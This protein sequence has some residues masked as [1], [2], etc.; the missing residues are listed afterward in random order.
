ME[1]SAPFLIT[2][3]SFNQCTSLDLKTLLCQIEFLLETGWY[4]LNMALDI[5]M[6]CEW[7]HRTPRMLLSEGTVCKGCF[8]DLSGTALFRRAQ[9]GSS[10]RCSMK[11]LFSTYSPSYYDGAR[12]QSSVKGWRMSWFDSPRPRPTASSISSL[13]FRIEGQRP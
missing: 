1:L 7:F 11:R 5:Q 13:G 6:Q 10:S 12:P 9:I 3:I 8:I 4:E 2:E